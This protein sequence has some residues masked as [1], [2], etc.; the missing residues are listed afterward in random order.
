MLRHTLTFLRTRGFGAVLPIDHHIYL[1]KIT[2]MLIAAYSLFHTIMH[3]I[4]FS[5]CPHLNE[6]LEQLVCTSLLY[7]KKLIINLSFLLPR[8]DSR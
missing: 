8:C 1:H 5:K 4:N 3:L 6:L 7:N 2:G